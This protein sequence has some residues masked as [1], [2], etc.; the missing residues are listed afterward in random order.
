MVLYTPCRSKSEGFLQRQPARC[1]TPGGI[2]KAL[3]EIQTI[4]SGKLGRFSVLV[5]ALRDLL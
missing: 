1:L 4:N 5:A 2:P 3:R